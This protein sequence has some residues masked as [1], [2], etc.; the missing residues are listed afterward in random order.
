MSRKRLCISPS[1]VF[2]SLFL[3][4][5]VVC[6]NSWTTGGLTTTR[7]LVIGLFA[8]AAG[9]LVHLFGSFAKIVIGDVAMDGYAVNLLSE[10]TPW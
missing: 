1:W 8:V 7:V 2:Y 3:F 4:F 10:P 9:S 5:V 6:F